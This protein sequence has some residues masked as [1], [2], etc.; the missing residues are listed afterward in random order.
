MAEIG[1]EFNLF[2]PAD[3]FNRVT[4]GIGETNFPKNRWFHGGRQLADFCEVS[5]QRVFGFREADL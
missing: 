1:R 4:D 5:Q 3:S 2:Y